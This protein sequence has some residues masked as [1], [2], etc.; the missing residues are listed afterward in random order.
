MGVLLFMVSITIA[1][2]CLKLYDEP[3]R[4]WLRRRFLVP[5]H[6]A[7]TWSLDEPSRITEGL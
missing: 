2:T 3:V 1:Y 6:K 5:A 4:E 7:E